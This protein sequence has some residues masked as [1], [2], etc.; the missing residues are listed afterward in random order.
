MAV[1]GKVAEAFDLAFAVDS[2]AEDFVYCLS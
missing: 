1:F 2:E